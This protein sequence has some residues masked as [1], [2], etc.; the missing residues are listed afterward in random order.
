MLNRLFPRQVDNRF[1]GNRAALWLLGAFVALKLI[2]SVRSILDTASVVT[3]DGIPIDSFGPEAARQILLLFALMA[4]GQLMLAL[5]A[6]TIMLRYR[7]LVPFICLLL[8]AERVANRLIVQS[9]SG[10]GGDNPIVWVMAVT[11]PTLLLL[12]LVLSLIP[13]RHRHPGDSAAEAME[14][15]K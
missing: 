3:G 2:M 10:A 12:A 13:R 4:L 14:E 5:I 9:H 15:G 8:L 11:L 7:A 6:L 1:D